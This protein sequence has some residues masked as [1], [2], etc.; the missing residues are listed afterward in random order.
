MSTPIERAMIASRRLGVL[1][2]L[3]EVRATVPDVAMMHALHASSHRVR[4]DRE[5]VR[6]DYK[7]LE[8]VM[9][10]STELVDDRVLEATITARG[11]LVA[12]GNL[13]VDGIADALLER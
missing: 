1:Q 4:V 9:C 12:Q 8:E 10:V 5:A 13:K 6:A 2:I 3:A 7:F 11:A